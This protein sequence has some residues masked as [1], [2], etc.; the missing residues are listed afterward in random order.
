MRPGGLR[1]RARTCPLTPEYLAAWSQGED[2]AWQLR[3]AFQDR[4]FLPPTNIY[5]PFEEPDMEQRVTD[6]TYSFR[7]QEMR[8]CARARTHTHTYHTHTHTA[9]TV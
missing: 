9:T 7:E 3:T 1:R 2:V 4:F 5:D 6:L 8:Q